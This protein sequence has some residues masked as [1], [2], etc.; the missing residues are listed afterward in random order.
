MHKAI[1]LN[2]I[3]EQYKADVL[4]N[5]SD[6]EE[7]NDQSRA[8]GGQRYGLAIKGCFGPN[9]GPGKKFDDLIEVENVLE[10]KLGLKEGLDYQVRVER[11]DA[12]NKG[13]N[14]ELMRELRPLVKYFVDGT[15]PQDHRIY[16]IE[17]E[18]EDRLK[19]GEE[20]Q[21]QTD[22]I[23]KQKLSIE[24]EEGL[25]LKRRNR[26]QQEARADQEEKVWTNN[27][28]KRK[29]MPKKNKRQNPRKEQM[30]QNSNKERKQRKTMA[31]EKNIDPQ[32]SGKP[33]LSLN[34]LRLEKM[35][36]EKQKLRLKEKYESMMLE[37]D[38]FQFISRCGIDRSVASNLSIAD[39]IKLQ[40]AFP[41]LK[42]F[43]I[44]CFEPDSKN[45]TRRAFIY[46]RDG[47]EGAYVDTMKR[48]LSTKHKIWD[49]GL[50][51]KIK[52]S[53]RGK[54]VLKITKS[55]YSNFE[56]TLI[57]KFDQ[58]GVKHSTFESALNIELQLRGN[59][60]DPRAIKD[61]YE[62]AS[63]LLRAE[64]FEFD[65]NYPDAYEFYSIFSSCGENFISQKNNNYNGEVFIETNERMRKLTIRGIDKKKEQVFK[66]LRE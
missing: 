44:L 13:Q 28:T 62:F 46:Q 35:E 58:L 24:E 43:Y 4:K 41:E 14:Q 3:S 5:D 23:D 26:Y 40:K 38:E 33:K 9:A 57:S 11:T 52:I 54:Y 19:D 61:A 7:E 6:E 8:A 12:A 16:D 31:V 53:F 32:Q 48:F 42:N 15:L 30:K 64:E 63:D 36:L 1:D 2:A 27:K 39:R 22:V 45:I 17:K 65:P 60:E 10:K 56:D 20:D 18:I 25:A 55:I 37:V 47:M 29:G 50:Q 59:V 34:E 66:D 49:D 21:P 51:S